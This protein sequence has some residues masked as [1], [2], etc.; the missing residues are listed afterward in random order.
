[1]RFMKKKVV[2]CRVP[3]PSPLPSG[4]RGFPSESQVRVPAGYP[5]SD[6]HV[7]TWRTNGGLTLCL[8]SE[9]TKAHIALKGPFLA[10]F[11]AT[12]LG[13]PAVSSEAGSTIS[14]FPGIS[15]GKIQS[16]A[17]FLKVLTLQAVEVRG[18]CSTGPR[19]KGGD[20]W[21]LFLKWKAT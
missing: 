11:S 13:I 3:W 19:V 21:R 4:V 10:Y 18:S 6:T 16:E 20:K 5:P 7:P 9:V 1:M 17:C 8:A 2:E 15:G 14:G 12:L